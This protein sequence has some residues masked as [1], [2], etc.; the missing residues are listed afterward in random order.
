MPEQVTERLEREL[1]SIIGNGFAVMY[2]IAQKLVWDSND[3]GYLVGS[4]GSVGSSF[5]A[6]MSGITEVNPLS[7]HYICPKCHFTD[8]D[9][10]FVKPYAMMGMSGCDMP[11][12][13]C[14]H[15]GTKLIKEGHDIPFET[16]L[17]FKGNKEP[18]ID[19]NFSGE[20]QSKAHKYVE[21]IFGEGKAFRA[22]TIGTIAEKTAYGYVKGYFE[23]RNIHKRSCEIARLAKGCTGVKR[24]TGQ[25]PGGIIV[26]PYENDIYEFTA[27]QHPANDMNTDII[28][29]HFEYHSIDHNLL[30]LDILG[31]DDPTMIRRLQ[32]ITGIA[33]ETIPLDDPDVMELF[34]GTDVLGIKPE[35]I[36]G[37]EMGSLGVPEFGTEFVIQMLKDTKPKCFSDLVRISGLSHGTDVWLGNAQ[38]LIQ[39]GIAEI[40]GCICCRD[41]IMTYLINKGLDK[42][43]SFTIMESVRKG[44]GLRSEWEEEMTSHDVPDWYIDS[45]KKIKYMFPKAHAA[46]YVMMG[47]RVA[48]FKV[49]YPLAYYAAFFAIRAS[50]F[51]Y[52]IMCRGPEILK[53]AMD[54][55]TSVPKDQQS[56]KDQDTIRDGR[57][58][59]EMYARGF[60]FMPIDIYKAKARECLIIDGKIMPPLSSIEGLGEKACDQIEEAA[61]AA[62]D[63]KFTS[64]ENFR[65][66]AKISKSNVD[67]MVELGILTG[68][69]ETDQLTFDFLMGM[70]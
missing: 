41:D 4:R 64:L 11:D 19:L 69:P 9:S 30:K 12:R 59:Q 67:K 53:A 51:S 42:E 38:E 27:I 24:T 47:W 34:H 16:F 35:D 31:H 32:D 54:Q 25:H 50:A 21:V 43:Q 37:I 44:K 63:S 29:T 6:T 46:A 33:P 60:E 3:H 17:G 10:E 2:I 20:Y 1:K 22:G 65:V 66:Q 28:T 23:D 7:C 49:H 58:C 48:W 52:E 57:L 39:K 36:G 45:C 15:C 13:D 18:D 14:P 8:F 40:S 5:V 70:N 56:K 68:L 55:L 62:Q 61:K 26:V